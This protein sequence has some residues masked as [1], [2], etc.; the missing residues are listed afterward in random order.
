M[1]ACVVVVV[2]VVCA[3]VVWCDVVWHGGGL[4]GGCVRAYVQKM[5][6]LRRERH[7]ERR[8]QSSGPRGGGGGRV[9]GPRWDQSA[10][11][12]DGSNAPILK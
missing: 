10:I 3:R 1:R 4:V 2:V 7:S 9:E 11:L 12:N 8:E 5:P 6:A